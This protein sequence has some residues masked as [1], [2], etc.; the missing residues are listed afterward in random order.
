MSLDNLNLLV[1]ANRIAEKNSAP[2]LINSALSSLALISPVTH[3]QPPTLTQV[4]YIFP[5]FI[6]NSRAVQ[7][8][9][10]HRQKKTKM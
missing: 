5:H 3:K 7:P 10:H 4:Q 9:P 2:N 8:N 1:A 6:Y